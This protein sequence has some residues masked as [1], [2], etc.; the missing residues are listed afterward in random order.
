MCATTALQPVIRSSWMLTTMAQ[1]MYVTLYRGAEGVRS[2]C[3]SSVEIEAGTKAQRQK[4]KSA[5]WNVVTCDQRSCMIRVCRRPVS[6][7]ERS[8]SEGG[9]A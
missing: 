3:V 6:S 2:Q 9:M 5:R 4:V 7:A 8:G 1:E